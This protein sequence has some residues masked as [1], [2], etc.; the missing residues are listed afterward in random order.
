MQT[1]RAFPAAPDIHPSRLQLSLSL[2]ASSKKARKFI[3]QAVLST[4]QKLRNSLENA[5]L[6]TSLSLSLS[7]AEAENILR[8]RKAQLLLY[9]RARS[10]IIAAR[11]E[12]I[13]LTL[14]RRVYA[15]F[16]CN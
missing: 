7:L 4:A 10:N 8:R 1:Q 13:L 9:R 11:G 15:A 14:R 3:P 5:Q 16:N 2:E 12:L 6:Y